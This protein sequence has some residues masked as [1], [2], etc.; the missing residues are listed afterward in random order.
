MSFIIGKYGC[1]ASIV[2]QFESTWKVC[3]DVLDTKKDCNLPR[4]LLKIF[5]YGPEKHAVMR[6]LKEFRRLAESMYEAE[7]KQEWPAEL[8]WRDPTQ[9]RNKYGRQQSHRASSPPNGPY[10]PSNRDNG[11]NQWQ[12][13]HVN[14]QNG[15]YNNNCQ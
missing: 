8:A 12:Q 1:N 3:A 13:G 5:C 14:Y 4:D 7:I 9:E 6:A 2:A 11:Q 10:T 15:G